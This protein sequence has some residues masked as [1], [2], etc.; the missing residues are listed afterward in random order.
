MYCTHCL[1]A[2]CKALRAVSGGYDRV[3]E[4]VIRLIVKAG[5]KGMTSAELT[6]YS[7]PLRTFNDE[8]KALMFDQLESEGIVVKHRFP[9]GSGRGKYRDAFLFAQVSQ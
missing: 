4:D 8:Q 5:D 1:C 2:S 3:K 7:R 9:A 6:R